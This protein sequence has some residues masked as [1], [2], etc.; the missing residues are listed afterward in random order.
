ME[1]YPEE[2]IRNIQKNDILRRHNAYSPCKEALTVRRFLQ[3]KK[4]VATNK[5]IP[6]TEHNTEKPLPIES[7]LSRAVEVPQLEQADDEGNISAD[8]IFNSLEESQLAETSIKDQET[9]E[10]FII[11]DVQL[12]PP[13]ENQDQGFNKKRLMDAHA[14]LF[15]SSVEP[16]KKSKGQELLAQY[17]SR[18]RTSK[19]QAKASM[20]Q[21][22]RNLKKEQSQK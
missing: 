16:P 9:G 22:L 2:P 3:L 6:T 14:E 5:G 4:Y 12:V 17:S 8:N 1:D 15:G 18:Y 19:M 20:S 11:D 7:T 10:V 21:M 13:N